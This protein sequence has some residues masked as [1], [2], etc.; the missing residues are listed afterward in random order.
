MNKVS[1]NMNSRVQNERNESQNEQKSLKMNKMSPRMNKTS[2]KI[3]IKANNEK[4]WSQNKQKSQ[5]MNKM[6]YPQKTCSP[7]SFLPC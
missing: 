6:K 1:L 2:L 5:R 7:P 4:N 3:N